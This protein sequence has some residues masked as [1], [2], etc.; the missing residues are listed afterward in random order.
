MSC[1]AVRKINELV[2]RVRL[3]K[4]HAYIISYLKEQM[5]SFM[6]LA[7]KQAQLIENLS[8]VFRSVMKKWNLSAGDFPNLDDF[9]AKLAEHDFSKFSLIR[10]KLLDDVETVLGFDFPRLM[11][12]LP[13]TFS[14]MNTAD[15]DAPPPL[16]STLP[17]FEAPTRSHVAQ[18]TSDYLPPSAPAPHI[19]VAIAAA[20]DNDDTN[21][22]GL[23]EVASLQAGTWSL[24]EYIPKYTPQFQSI[25]KN[26]LVT[27]GAAKGILSQSGLPV[28]SLRKIWELADIDKDGALDLQEFV[29]ALFITDMVKQGHDVPAALDEEMYPPGKV[30]K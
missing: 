30:R 16:P 18:A 23:N 14:S 10:Q 4:T 29:I 9:K 1:S 19:P 22:W 8:Q 17:T 20:D 3:A 13:R 25:Q 26:G 6:G 28:A 7:K 15:P 12:A 11:E 2:K 24:A 21:P 5:P 27:G